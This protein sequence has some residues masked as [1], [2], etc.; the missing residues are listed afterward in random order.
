MGYLDKLISNGV[1]LGELR[2]FG[3]STNKMRARKEDL[4]VGLDIPFLCQVSYVEVTW[5]ICSISGQ[6]GGTLAPS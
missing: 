5:G 6:G 3:F 2:L 1:M 4:D